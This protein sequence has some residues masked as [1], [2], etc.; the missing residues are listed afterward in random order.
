MSKVDDYINQFD[1]E[2]KQRLRQMRDIVTSEV[3]AA[4]EGIMY[5]L[6]GYKLN[7]KPLVYFGG[8]TNHIGLYA[9]PTGHEAFTE[10]FAAYKQ[11]KG[12]VQFPLDQPLPTALIRRVVQYR[13]AQADQ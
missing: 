9:T 12:S 10:E 8:F 13:K 2:T 11:G 1:D 6:V 5:G 7:E 4:E 3:P